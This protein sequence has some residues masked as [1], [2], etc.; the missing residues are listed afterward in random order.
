M[1][2]K[3][4][5]DIVADELINLRNCFNIYKRENTYQGDVKYVIKFLYYN[6]K[7]DAEL[8][9]N[10]KIERNNAF[11]YYATFLGTK[12]IDAKIKPIVL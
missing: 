6:V 10:T 8:H 1:E 3:W 7:L 9:Y 11:A 5:Y 12:E 4:Y 2:D